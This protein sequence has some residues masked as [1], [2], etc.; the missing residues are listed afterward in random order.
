VAKCPKIRQNDKTGQQKITKSDKRG[1][2]IK[3]AQKIN[4][5]TPPKTQGLPVKDIPNLG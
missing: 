5:K 2:N 1:P 4:I 3:T